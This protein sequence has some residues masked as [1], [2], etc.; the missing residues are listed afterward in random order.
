MPR[1][2][3]L[4]ALV[5][6][7]LSC[8]DHPEAPPAPKAVERS[9]PAAA[10]PSGAIS[11][12]GIRFTPPAGWTA[13]PPR[14]MRVATFQVPKAAGDRD[15]TECAAYYFGAG[16]GGAVQAN[17]ARWLGQFQNAP[18]KWDRLDERKVAGIPV[19]EVEQAGTFLWS[20]SPMSPVTTPK[21]GWRLLGAII[22]APNG[23]VFVKMVGPTASVSA[24]K[25]GFEQLL[26]SIGRS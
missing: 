2:L 25:A 20:A 18:E 22:E 4:T 9:E 17:L 8:Q 13:E 11:V 10:A 1:T 6:L 21:S 23:L 26:G 24:A 5:L 3:P 7:A 16:Q 12:A 14:P 15:E 19:T